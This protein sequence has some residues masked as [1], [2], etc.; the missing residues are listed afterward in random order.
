MYDKL[1]SLDACAE[2][3]EYVQDIGDIQEAW[4]AHS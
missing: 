2:A 4:D 1:V 3:L